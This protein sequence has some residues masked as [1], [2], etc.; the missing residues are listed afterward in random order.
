MPLRDLRPDDPPCLGPYRLRGRL[1]AGG[2]GAVY[3][4]FGVDGASVAV[5]TLLPGANEDARRRLRQEAELLA[6]VSNPHLA[7][8][9]DADPDAVV[10]W[11]ALR[12]VAGPALSE[13]EEPLGADKLL[14]LADGLATGLAALHDVG[15]VHRDV[16]PS[17]VILTHA[18][19]VLVDLGIARAQDMT[20]LTQTGVVV[21]SPAWMAPEQLRGED[22]GPATDMWGWGAAVAFASTGRAPFGEGPMQALAWRIQHADPDLDGVPTALLES[23]SASLSKDPADRPAIGTLKSPQ[24]GTKLLPTG[25]AEQTPEVKRT[26]AYTARMAAGG[27]QEQPDSRPAKSAVI[28]K[29]AAWATAILVLAVAL[30]AGLY[31]LDRNFDRTASP[32]A[33]PTE[34]SEITQ[35]VQATAEPQA[36][37]TTSS[38]VPDQAE[39]DLQMFT[40]VLGDNFKALVFQL[41]DLSGGASAGSE[42]DAPILGSWWALADWCATARRGTVGSCYDQASSYYRHWF[43]RDPREINMQTWQ[44]AGAIGEYLVRGYELTEA[45]LGRTPAHQY[46]PELIAGR[47]GTDILCTPSCAERIDP[48]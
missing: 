16:K 35:P 10:P 36:P 42:R 17:N 38:I 2:M 46:I 28:T 3:L 13:I 20:A 9:R 18:G 25:T 14:Q 29:V 22:V 19:P 12:Y 32:G 23:V 31:F 30:V 41:Q 39:A 7:E 4:G 24:G 47:P 33:T 45:A 11:L 27:E 43:D 21:G 15:I 37:P 48:P 34:T 40:S 44:G 26:S 5:K 8:F 1:G 6:R